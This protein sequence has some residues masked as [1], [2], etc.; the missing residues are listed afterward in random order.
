MI[1]AADATSLLARNAVQDRW[2]P[3]VDRDGRRGVVASFEHDASQLEARLDSGEKL[4][5]PRALVLDGPEH[6]YLFSQSFAPLLRQPAGG[7]V[8]VPIVEEHVQVQKRPV[9]RDHVRVTTSST[10]REEV[11]DV[12]LFQESIAV[13]RVPIGQVVQ[14]AIAPRQ[15]GDTLVFPVYEEVLVVEK[16]LVLKEEIRVTRVRRE[17]HEPQAVQLRRGEVHVEHVPPSGAGH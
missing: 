5:L 7:E 1:S 8:I 12:P 10:T 14:A 13:E 15:E 11:V 9:E 16:R 4:F 17:V 2:Y 3:I 6:T